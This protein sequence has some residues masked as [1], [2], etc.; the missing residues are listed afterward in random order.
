MQE[1]GFEGSFQSEMY[2][3]EGFLSSQDL[4]LT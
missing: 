3:T 2:I 4:T 1:R